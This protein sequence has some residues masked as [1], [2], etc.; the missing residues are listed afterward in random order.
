MAIAA[1]C[2]ARACASTLLGRP[3]FLFNSGDAMATEEEE[4]D[5]SNAKSRCELLKKGELMSR[6]P[7]AELTTI[8]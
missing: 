2:A 8:C 7:E 4:D 1:I 5:G 3:L 6:S